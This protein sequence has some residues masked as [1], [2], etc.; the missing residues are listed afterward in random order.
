MTRLRSKTFVWEPHRVHPFSKP[1][2]AES[3][4]AGDLIFRLSVF[5]EY[6]RVQLR[7]TRRSQTRKQFDED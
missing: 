5:A 1:A 7:R 6:F 4:V 3:G 2:R